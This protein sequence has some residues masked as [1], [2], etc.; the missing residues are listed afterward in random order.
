[1]K[2]LFFLLLIAAALFACAE[3]EDIFICGDYHYT[4]TTDGSAVIAK[5]TGNEQKVRIPAELDGHAIVGIGDRAFFGCGS[6]H[7]VVF[8]DTV[9]FIGDSAFAECGALSSLDI[10]GAVSVI[11]SDAFRDC[12]RL[13]SVKFRE[14]LTEIGDHAFAGCNSL[15]RAELPDSLVRVGVNPWADCFSISWIYVSPYSPGLA[16]IDGVLYSKAD[17]RLICCPRCWRGDTFDIPQGVRSIGDEA[18]LSAAFITSVTIPDSVTE[19]GERAFF[20]CGKLVSVT[21]PDS[22]TAIGASAFPDCPELILTVGKG[23]AAEAY[24][25]DGGIPYICAEQKKTR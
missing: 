19:I 25:A 12:R 5:Y 7:S 1:M 22:A 18:F 6:F 23:S 9:S 10:P 2:R 13:S 21:V 11:G 14:G 15:S 24:C 4:L 20:G 3:A 16:A 17:K 8:T